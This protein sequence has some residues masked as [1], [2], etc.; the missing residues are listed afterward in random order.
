MLYLLSQAVAFETVSATI[1]SNATVCV[2][3]DVHAAMHVPLFECR[4]NIFISKQVSKHHTAHYDAS[5][6]K[7]Y[8]W[9]GCGVV[10]GLCFD[11]QKN[12]AVNASLVHN[13]SHNRCAAY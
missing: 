3:V 7:S 12:P 10:Y 4:S 8:R 2:R 5:V 6:V 1:I 11:L 9:F 13:R